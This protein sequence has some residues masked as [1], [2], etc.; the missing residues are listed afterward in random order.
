M[1]FD[2]HLPTDYSED[3]KTKLKQY[4]FRAAELGI[5][6]VST[7]HYDAV[8]PGP[9]NH[10]PGVPDCAAMMQEYGALRSRN[11]AV[12]IELGMELSVLEHNRGVAR[13]QPW[14]YILGSLHV[15]DGMNIYFFELMCGGRSQREI[16][17]HYFHAY[18]ETL[19]AHDFVNAVG[20]LDHICRYNSYSDRNLHLE[21]YSDAIDELFAVMIDRGLAL[22][23]NT[24]R[25]NE[26]GAQAAMV[27]V[28]E[29]FKQRG[30][31]MFTVGSDAHNVDMLGY[32]LNE[33]YAMGEA[34]GL[35]AVRFYDGKPEFIKS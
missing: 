23:L 34:A 29:R 33:A 9:H 8:H 35:R 2:C 1:L 30:G 25:F 15:L 13:S 11:F 21:Q 12:G 24:K 5:G 31:E 26:P 27:P 7:D 6:L 16:Y 10:Q 14:D 28:L 4:L 22:E 3:S 19:R 17:E 20:H 32:K 18:A